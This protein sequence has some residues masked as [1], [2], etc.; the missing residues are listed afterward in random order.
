ML[1]SMLESAGPGREDRYFYSPVGQS[2][3]DT[4]RRFDTVR[5]TKGVDMPTSGQNE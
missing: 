2:L 1:F 4:N 3:C 5:V